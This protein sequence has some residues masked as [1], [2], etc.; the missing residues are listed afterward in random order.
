[1]RPDILLTEQ[2]SDGSLTDVARTKIIKEGWE[3]TESAA[4]EKK[5]VEEE[6]TDMCLG[7]RIKQMLIDMVVV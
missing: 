1:M 2:G 3:S 5:W 7:R 4:E 6:A